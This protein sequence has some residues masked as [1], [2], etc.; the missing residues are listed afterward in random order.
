MTTAWVVRQGTRGRNAEEMIEAGYMGVDFIGDYDLS[1]HLGKGSEAFRSAAIQ[2]FL[3]QEPDKTKVAAGLAAGNL[4]WAC[5]GITEGDLV[6][7]PKPDR[8]YQYGVVTGGYEYHPGKN[9][10]HRRRVDWRGSF[11]RDDM[12]TT[13]ASSA[14]SLMTVFQ[15]T[16]HA[17]ELSTLT[18][19]TDPARPIVQAISS[20]VEDQL[21]FQMEK[22]LEDFLVH[23]WRSTALGQEYDIYTEDGQPVGQQYPTD[24]GPMD[25][26]AISKDKTRLLVVELKRGRASD[27][28]VGQIQRYMGFVQDALLEPGQSVEGVIIAQEDDL[29]IRRALSMARNIRFMKYRVEFHLEAAD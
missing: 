12:S 7:A 14:G 10:P 1:P 16:A 15:L 6:L 18:H 29:R 26:L 8:T 5:E 22:Q 24:T 11:S 2:V 25:I 19:L 21:A 28:V 17:S 13:L 4:W 3:G 23:N 9:L 27:S 20:H